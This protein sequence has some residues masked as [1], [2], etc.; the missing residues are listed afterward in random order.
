MSKDFRIFE[1]QEPFTNLRANLIS[2]L[3]VL[4]ANISAKRIWL[5]KGSLVVIF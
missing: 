2:A 4:Y 3:K 1:N 5:I